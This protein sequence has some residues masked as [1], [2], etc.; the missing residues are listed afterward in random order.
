MTKQ[1]R[2]KVIK[3]VENWRG[4]CS[5]CERGGVKLLW[6]KVVDGNTVKCC[7][8]CSNKK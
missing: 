5:I 7:K 1:K 3:K 4:T 8:I 2:G 6:T